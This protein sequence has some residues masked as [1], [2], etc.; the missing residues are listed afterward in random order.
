MTGLP[1][2]QREAPWRRFG[3]PEYVIKHPLPPRR[4]ALFVGG[5]VRAPAQVE[6][7]DLAYQ[8]KEREQTSDLHCVTTWSTTGI[9]WGGYRF[10]D[11]HELLLERVSPRRPRWLAFTG[12]DGFRSCLSLTDALADDVLVAVRLN[13]APLTHGGPLRL[14]APAHYGYKSVKHLYAI[15]YLRDYRAGSAT[16]KE[17]PRGRVARE[18]R[19]RF[20]PGW[21]WRPLWRTLL[22]GAMAFAE[23]AS[24]R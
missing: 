12:L 20:L 9:R 13:G 15:D 3:L 23:R 21:C 7:A 6:W 14:V 1:P 11:V 18:E 4:P 22:P 24:Q 8:L 17:H 19:S 10:R 2:G 5:D 16:W